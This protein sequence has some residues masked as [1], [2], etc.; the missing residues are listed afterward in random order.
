VVLALVFIF[1]SIFF[2]C[3]FLVVVPYL[4]L[5]GTSWLVNL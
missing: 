2:H 3:V 5:S 1:A 4:I